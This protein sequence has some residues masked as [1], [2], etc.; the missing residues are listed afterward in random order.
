MPSTSSTARTFLTARSR[1]SLLASLRL[2]VLPRAVL[3]AAVRDPAP[4]LHVAET[5][6]ADVAV[7][8]AVVVVQNA[9]VA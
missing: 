3:P 9:A 8:E 1:S 5:L 6:L 7:V 4:R 2:L